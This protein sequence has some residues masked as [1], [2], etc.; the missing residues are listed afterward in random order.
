[1][2]TEEGRRRTRRKAVK[3]HGGRPWAI[4]E[5]E[6]IDLKFQ[7]DDLEFQIGDLKFRDVRRVI[8]NLKLT[9]SNFKV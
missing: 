9:I 8:S 5:F 2:R 4:S 6:I 1:M 7:I 3:E